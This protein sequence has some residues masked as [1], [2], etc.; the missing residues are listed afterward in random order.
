MPA[1]PA[2]FRLSDLDGSNGFVIEGIDADDKSGISVSDTGDINN[3]GIA[4]L[5][6]A[7]YS[8][9][10]NGQSSAGESY[11]VFGR[12]S[13]FVSPFA[14]STLDGSNGFVIEGINTGDLSGIQVNGAGDI[15]GDGI[16]DLIIGAHAA[17]PSGQAGAGESYVVFGSSSGFNSSLSLVLM[18]I[19]GL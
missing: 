5:I 17:D 2:K 6:I 10:P 1:F 4:D 7:A 8:A 11:V 15:N 12:G 16:A 14:L 19:T 18:V 9:D 13:G 3:D